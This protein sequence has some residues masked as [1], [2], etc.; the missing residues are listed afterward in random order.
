MYLGLTN[1]LKENKRLSTPDFMTLKKLN[2]EVGSFYTALW[3]GTY[4]IVKDFILGSNVNHQPPSLYRRVR[5]EYGGCQVNGPKVAK[6][7]D[8]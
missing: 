8:R 5:K 6:F 1:E 3:T 4:F 2:E 7:L